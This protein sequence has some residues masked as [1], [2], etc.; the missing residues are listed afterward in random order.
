M[1]ADLYLPA[2][3]QAC[4]ER[5]GQAAALVGQV[6]RLAEG[7]SRPQIA[8][9]GLR[10]KEA[11]TL[12]AYHSGE[13]VP[14]LFDQVSEAADLAQGELAAA[15]CTLARQVAALVSNI[16]AL[17]PTE[18]ADA[19]GPLT[20]TADL[21]ALLT[22]GSDEA[23]VRR[24]AALL[25]QHLL[26]R[27][28][29][30]ILEQAG[31]FISDVLAGNPEGMFSLLVTHRFLPSLAS[32]CASQADSFKHLE[33]ALAPLIPDLSMPP[34]ETDSIP[35]AR[36]LL[37]FHRLASAFLE[38]ISHLHQQLTAACQASAL[39]SE[40][41]PVLLENA[42]TRLEELWTDEER[43]HTQTQAMEALHPLFL[44]SL[45]A[46]PDLLT[47]LEVKQASPLQRAYG[48]LMEY[49]LLWPSILYM[50]TRELATA[51]AV[52][53]GDFR[54]ALSELCSVVVLLLAP[55]QTLP[56]WPSLQGEQQLPLAPGVH[57]V[58]TDLMGYC[59]LQTT[60]AAQVAMRDTHLRRWV[61]RALDEKPATSSASGLILRF[62][63]ML[64][65]YP[66]LWTE[67]LTAQLRDVL[68]QHDPH[69]SD[70]LN[71]L[72][73]ELQGLL[74][75]RPHV[76]IEALL[77]AV[78]AQVTDD[79]P[80]ASA[81][82]RLYALVQ[83]NIAETLAEGLARLEQ[84][85]EM[86]QEWP[87][88][89]RRDALW[90]LTLAR[91]LWQASIE[92]HGP[93]LY[94][95]LRATCEELTTVG[96]PLRALLTEHEPW[97]SEQAGQLPFLS[98]LIAHLQ[99]ELPEEGPQPACADPR[100]HQDWKLRLL[101][102]LLQALVVFEENRHSRYSEHIRSVT[103]LPQ[104][105]YVLQQC[106]SAWSFPPEGYFRDPYNDT[107]RRCGA[108]EIAGSSGRG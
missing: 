67:V 12:H 83:G 82:S 75:D 34:P 76:R 3:L 70:Q 73:A 32:Q 48:C 46:S 93:L 26:S 33:E 77:S 96:D 90:L 23:I 94:A 58:G 98:N 52:L 71:T 47:R 107:V 105:L 88:D 42:S 66:P 40:A 51:R 64:Q 97:P 55:E 28:E 2:V 39:W 81:A 53:T 59:Y 35:A 21:L 63:H 18:E 92:Q 19:P 84:E 95:T 31:Q 24:G 80:L 57:M 15:T 79:S 56:G 103:V 27:H 43:L 45:P 74:E 9:A 36:A 104:I 41:L 108:Y 7:E 22:A 16:P 91:T 6:T 50:V 5:Y 30:A 60:N 8:E 1:G 25:A 29:S 10:L 14:A 37:Q 61:E 65:G 78:Q 38:T 4:H 102:T 86:R 106:L 20:L 62:W 13:M 49:R 99:Q 72:L 11:L 54:A 101:R 17:T 100:V 44:R 68:R 87:A 85:V 89:R 69:T